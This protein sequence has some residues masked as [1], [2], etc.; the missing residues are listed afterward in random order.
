MMP[1]TQLTTDKE[2]NTTLRVRNGTLVGYSDCR[3][4]CIVN[5]AFPNTVAKQR[6]LSG[7]LLSPTILCSVNSQFVCIVEM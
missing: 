6:C 2:S 3:V 4:P 7:G 1:L 5:I